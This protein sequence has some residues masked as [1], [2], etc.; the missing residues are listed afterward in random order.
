MLVVISSMDDPA[1]GA[2]LTRWRA[3]GVEARALTCHDLARPGWR[4]NLDGP[5]T[6]VIGGA[7]V[8]VTAVRGVITRLAWVTASELPFMA[9]PDRDYAAAEMQGFLVALLMQLVRLGVPVINRPTPG[10]LAGP[11]WSPE[12][13]TAAAARAGVEVEPIVHA[14]YAG[15]LVVGGP[16]A[17]A[18]RSVT[19]VGDRVLGD[20]PAPLHAAARTIAKAAGTELL[21]VTFAARAAAPTFLDAG[22]AIDLADPAIADAVAGRFA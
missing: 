21:R 10:C 12:A 9:A 3:A 7:R 13:W 14:A 16:A 4:L 5:P 22:P 1:V 18:R 8:P 17:P 2:A 6:L 19:V 15:G 20:A 11:T